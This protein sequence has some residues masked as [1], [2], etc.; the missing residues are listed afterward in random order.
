MRGISW[1]AANQLASQEGLCTMEW[2][3]KYFTCMVFSSYFMLSRGLDSSVSS[4][5]RLQGGKQRNCGSRTIKDKTFVLLQGPGS[6]VG[7][8]TCYGLDGLLIETRWGRDFRTHLYRTCGPPTHLYNGNRASFAGV[9]RSG[10]GVHHP[11]ISS[12]E[13]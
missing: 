11:H 7:I 8:A 3:S 5:N 10:C 1:L 6:S 12:S 9:K 2:V 13:V 4:V